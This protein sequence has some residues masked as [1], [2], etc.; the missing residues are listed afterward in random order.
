[1]IEGFD[2]LEIPSADKSSVK[3]NVKRLREFKRGFSR[4]LFNGIDL[5]ND[6]L[7]AVG[8]DEESSR[9]GAV[10]NGRVEK[11]EKLVVQLAAA[12]LFFHPRKHSDMSDR[13]E[14]VFTDH[15]F[16]FFGRSNRY[17]G[18]ASVIS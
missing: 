3:A 11:Y 2:R 18:S 1:M 4:P 8:T 10:R 15:L 16:F 13:V 9:I 14:V 7:G 5:F 12:P 17:C 6:L